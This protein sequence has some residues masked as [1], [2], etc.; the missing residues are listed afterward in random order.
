MCVLGVVFSCLLILP[1]S[2]LADIVDYD[3]AKSGE[4]RTGIYMATLNLVFKLGLALG[5]GVA[6]GF[7]DIIGFDA[8]AATH[9]AYDVLVIRI[10]FSGINS[11]LLIPAILILWKFPITKKVQQELRQKIRINAKNS[12]RDPKSNFTQL[13]TKPMATPL[14]PDNG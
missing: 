3:T 10:A 14:L 4:E 12:K 5:V 1:A 9:T 7:L 13:S 8:A 11:V 6:Y 2:I